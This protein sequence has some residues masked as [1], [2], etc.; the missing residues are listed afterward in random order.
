MISSYA[1]WNTLPVVVK[2]VKEV[3]FGQVCMVDKG[4][5]MKDYHPTYCMRKRTDILS[6]AWYYDADDLLPA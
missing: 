1:T 5:K 6:Y 2:T 4:G 3:A